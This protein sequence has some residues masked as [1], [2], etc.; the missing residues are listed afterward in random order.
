MIVVYYVIV[1]TFSISSFLLWLYAIPRYFYLRKTKDICMSGWIIPSVSF[2]IIGIDFGV[3]MNEVIMKYRYSEMSGNLVFAICFFLLVWIV[4]MPILWFL[5]NYYIK[6]ENDLILI[7]SIFGVKKKIQISKINKQKSYRYYADVNEKIGFDSHIIINYEGVYY[8]MLD[9]LHFHYER[10]NKFTEF[11]LKLKIP[12]ISKE[13]YK[14]LLKE[15][16]PKSLL[17][18]VKKRG[19]KTNNMITGPFSL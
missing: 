5:T 13:D 9:D 8:S 4:C 11:Y 15:Y 6:I 1:N 2:P 18:Y 12:N 17:L 7:S 3:F 19:S 16:K 10:N 14:K